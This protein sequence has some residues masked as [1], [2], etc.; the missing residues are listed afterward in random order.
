MERGLHNT[1]SVIDVLYWKN[2]L[3]CDATTHV[4]KKTGHADRF[5]HGLAQQR[6][7]MKKHR[8][9]RKKTI[10]RKPTRGTPQHRNGANG[11]LPDDGDDSG[12]SDVEINVKKEDQILPLYR[13]QVP[14]GDDIKN[15]K[16]LERRKGQMGVTSPW[17]TRPD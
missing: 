2:N 6:M 8:T 16:G 4:I 1:Q 10:K 3:G 12:E 11:G 9:E 14:G 7:R 15:G 13:H 17:N 5:S